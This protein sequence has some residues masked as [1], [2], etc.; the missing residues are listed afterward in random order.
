MLKK[1]VTL[2]TNPA[3]YL[4]IRQAELEAEIKARDQAFIRVQ[5]KIYQ[6]A[7]AEGLASGGQVADFETW[8]IQDALKDARKRLTLYR[9]GDY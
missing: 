1:I 5:L 2:L 6:M 3:T 8:F 4:D 7:Q 9:A